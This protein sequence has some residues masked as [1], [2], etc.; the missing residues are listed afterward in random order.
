MESYSAF[1]QFYDAFTENVNYAQR[2]AYFDGLLLQHLGRRGL[3]LDLACGTGSLSVAL[4]QLGYEVIGVDASPEML[5]VAQ[6]KAASAG[7]H[8]LF[9]HQRME[10][11]DLF[12]TVAACVSAL[13]SLNHL[14]SRY[15]LEKAIGRTALF[16]E[17]GGVFVFDMNT[18]H[19]HKAVLANHCFVYEREK[20]LCVW[21]NRTKGLL[22]DITLDFFKEGIDTRYDR[23]GEQF[24]ERAYPLAEVDEIITKCGLTRIALYGDDTL[25]PPNLDAERWI[26]VC[27]KETSL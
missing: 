15:A 12:G 22:T 13:D 11:L 25:L 26:F 7:E 21:Q 9:L 3:L 10:T 1:A 20:A 2:A 5:S 14:T 24:S 6:Q 23:F 16:L 27:K 19:K 18:P 17:P 8:I 4:S